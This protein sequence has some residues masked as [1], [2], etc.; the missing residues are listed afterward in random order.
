M[1]AHQIGNKQCTYI[2]LVIKQCRHIKPEKPVTRVRVL[3]SEPVVSAV[4]LSQVSFRT[5]VL[6]RGQLYVMSDKGQV[7]SNIS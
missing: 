4:G 1:H 7:Y 5:R 2:K 6:S 3:I